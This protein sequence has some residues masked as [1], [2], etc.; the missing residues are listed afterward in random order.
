PGAESVARAALLRRLPASQSSS[1][2]REMK[3]PVKTGP[4]RF[5]A[6]REGHDSHLT[7]DHGDLRAR[8]LT[9]GPAGLSS[10][11]PDQGDTSAYSLGLH[12][13]L[14]VLS[15]GHPLPARRN[16]RRP[17]DLL[18]SRE[19]PRHRADSGD[20]PP[21]GARQPTPSPTSALPARR[22]AP[23][24][25]RPAAPARPAGTRDRKSTRL[26]SS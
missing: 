14:S 4:F 26:N 20:Q 17:A 12:V 7:V 3:G 24:G 1:N 19:H 10:Q 13:R 21:V 5:P 6:S 23:A 2:C 9:P 18:A 25:C 8:R 22:P 16:A 15:G 11:T